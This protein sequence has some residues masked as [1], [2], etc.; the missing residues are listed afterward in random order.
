MSRKI[1]HDRLRGELAYRGVTITDALDMQGISDYFEPSDAVIK[2]FQADVDIALMP[3][4]FRTAADAHR[5][6]DLI[7][8]LVAAVN[9]GLI[10][11]KE[12][13]RS[14][15]RIVLMKLR[16]GITPQGNDKPAPDR[17]VIGSPEHRAIERS[18]AQQ[19]ITLL[20]NQDGT[21]PLRAPLKAIFI[22]T[23]WAEQAQA[24]RRRFVELGDQ[25]VTSAAL[26]TTSWSA[27]KSAID[28]AQIVIL[29]TQSSGITSVRHDDP[30][31]EDE[32]AD[33][34]ISP[35]LL[36]T[37]PASDAQR[38]RDAMEYAKAR[39]K[40]VIHLT[41]RT[42]Y[43]VTAFDDIADATL[44]SYSY[45]GS[46]SAPNDTAMTAV[47][48][49]ILGVDSPIGRLP[50][51]IYTQNPDGTAGALRYPRGFGLRY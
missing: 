5:L 49:V 50:V 47:V 16:H 17:S 29:G 38:L 31:Q 6:S 23:P 3:V 28:A 30:P 44:A 40:T 21:L 12:L 41:M 36:A 4:E 48:D 9:S 22:L 18:I 19:A 33:T 37:P 27:Q 26:S 45:T 10:D 15:S 2:V 43:D 34:V 32:L 20:R 46:A 1:Q 35:R 25:D 42:P 7:D 39:H 24:M 13:D 11:R 51:A 14:V 8:R